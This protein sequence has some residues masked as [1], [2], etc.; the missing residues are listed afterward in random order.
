MERRLHNTGLSQGL[1]G[2][3]LIGYA[4]S[5]AL[6]I[7][8]LRV[9]IPRRRRLCASTLSVLHR[10]AAARSCPSPRCR[11]SQPWERSG[12]SDRSI[13][14][15]VDR[16]LVFLRLSYVM[17]SL[18]TSQATTLHCQT[19]GRCHA[20]PRT[21]DDVQIEFLGTEPMHVELC[22]RS[23]A[24]GKSQLAQGHCSVPCASDTSCLSR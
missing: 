11:L 1:V 21:A 20:F 9:G 10:A 8:A 24:S 7:V 6:S 18:L 23:R 16:Q 13:L 5:E 14:S 17:D 2:Q 22:A 12:W 3:A 19:H 15:S 4:G